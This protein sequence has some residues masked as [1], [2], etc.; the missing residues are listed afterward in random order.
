MV[1]VSVILGWGT[2]IALATAL[3]NVSTSKHGPF[4]NNVGLWCAISSGYTVEQFA[5]YFLP[6]STSYRLT[7]ILETEHVH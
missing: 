4:F 2:S 5:V 1:V 6:V 3:T 7:A